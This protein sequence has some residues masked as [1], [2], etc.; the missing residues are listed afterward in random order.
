MRLLRDVIGQHGGFGVRPPFPGPAVR[1]AF[2]FRHADTWPP[3]DW[4]ASERL[5]GADGARENRARMLARAGMRATSVCTVRQVHGDRVIRVD[6]PMEGA[7]EADGMITDVPGLALGILVADCAPVLLYDPVRRAVGACHSGW[8]GTVQQIVG[9]A[10][11]RMRAEYGTDP[12]DVHVAI[13]PCVRR[14]CYEVDDVVA[15]RVRQTPLER[16]LMPRFGR[17]GKYTFSL[18]HAIRLTAEACG[19]HPDRVYDSGICTSC[20]NRHLFSHRR[21]RDRAGRQM[22]AI[23]LVMEG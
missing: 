8:R 9:R 1:A 3:T 21:E 16:A 20:R 18:P 17:P 15:D 23:G 11:E 14:C 7:V 5:A 13:G 22:A 12:G 19:I 4:D 10:L 2:F 6:E